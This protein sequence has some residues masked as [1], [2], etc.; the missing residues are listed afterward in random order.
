MCNPSYKVHMETNFAS[1]A[2]ENPVTLRHVE[3]TTQR[4]WGAAVEK[5]LC[6]IIY[7][8]RPPLEWSS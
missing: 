1:A 3:P 7:V 8:F 6:C 4:R 5:C 2:P